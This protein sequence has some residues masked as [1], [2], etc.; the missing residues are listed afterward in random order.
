VRQWEEVARAERVARDAGAGTQT[1]CLE[2][3]ASLVSARALRAEARMKAIV[4]RAELARLT[5]ALS[6]EW[7]DAN[8]ED[9]A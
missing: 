1:N 4:A 6:L 5:G 2:A 9:G 7:L 3:Q 8:L